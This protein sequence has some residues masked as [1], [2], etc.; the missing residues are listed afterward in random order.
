MQSKSYFVA[1]DLTCD[2][3]YGWLKKNPSE[4]YVDFS[5]SETLEANTDVIIRTISTTAGMQRHC[6]HPESSMLAIH[7]LPVAMLYVLRSSILLKFLAVM[8]RRV[9]S[10]R[11]KILTLIPSKIF[12]Q[13]SM[14]FGICSGGTWQCHRRPCQAGRSV[15]SMPKYDLNSSAIP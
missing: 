6:P 15:A 10:T 14:S 4:R 7:Y 3:R 2:S 9:A 11:S 1:Q 12:L 8:P 5:E 13:V